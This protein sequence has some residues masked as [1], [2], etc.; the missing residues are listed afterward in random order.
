MKTSD[1]PEEVRALMDGKAAEPRTF[2][3]WMKELSDA[4]QDQLFGEYNAA[5]WRAGGITQGELL[6]QTTRPLSIESFAA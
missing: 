4:E 1:I 6:R 5:R 3:A 2:E